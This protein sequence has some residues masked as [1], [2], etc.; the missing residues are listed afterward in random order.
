M[1]CPKCGAE[2]VEGIDECPDCGVSLVDELPPEEKHTDLRLFRIA[3]MLALIGI[4][5]NFAVR[6][7]STFAQEL[8]RIAAVAK[9]ASIGFLL[10]SVFLAFFFIMFLRDYASGNDPKLRRASGWAIAASIIMI[11]VNFKRI[12]AIFGV[13]IS[14]YI[15]EHIISSPGSEVILPWLASLLILYF[16]VIFFRDA[17]NR[18][19]PILRKATMAGLIG[20]LIG[21]FHTTFVFWSY[22]ISPD[23]AWFHRFSTTLIIIFVPVIT[24]SFIL[25]FYFY[26]GFY[27]FIT[28]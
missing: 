10:S 14:P 22:L 5:Y 13:Y 24:I 23:P 19:L 17:L 9:I 2:Y 8:F 6:T 27:K 20:S 1:F 16:F 28:R 11:L 26:I 4:C 15:H 18:N 7:L 21:T 25:T 3:T 12:L